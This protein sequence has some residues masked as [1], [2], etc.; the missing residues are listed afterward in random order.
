MM[1]S[2]SIVLIK[3]QYFLFVNNL[4]K[5][6]GSFEITLNLSVEEFLLASFY[7][8]LELLCEI[9]LRHYLSIPSVLIVGIGIINQVAVVFQYFI[10]VF[11]LGHCGYVLNKLKNPINMFQLHSQF[12]VLLLLFPFL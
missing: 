6:L 4:T 5:T 7:S 8:M 11:F 12:V 9:C 3:N 2:R 10:I 1:Q